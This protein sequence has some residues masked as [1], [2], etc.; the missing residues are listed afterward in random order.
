[1]RKKTVN[2]WILS[3]H[4]GN[5]H[6]AYPVEGGL[7]DRT[8]R[9]L[10]PPLPLE[11][12]LNYRASQSKSSHQGDVP[13][14]RLYRRPRRLTR[15]QRA[16]VVGRRRSLAFAVT[17]ATELVLSLVLVETRVHWCGCVGDQW[18]LGGGLVV[19]DKGER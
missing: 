10:P 8:A 4:K 16:V 13:T 15:P 1:M 11:S 7:G 5:N 2:S 12:V 9:P 3:I 18:L 19:W 14:C 6:I 17:M